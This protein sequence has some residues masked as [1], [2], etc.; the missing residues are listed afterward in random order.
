MYRFLII[1]LACVTFILPQCEADCIWYGVCNPEEIEDGEMPLNCAVNAPGRPITDE[2]AQK[3]MLRLCPD[4]FT[5][6]K[7]AIELI[8]MVYDRE[9]FS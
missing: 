8:P 6:C 1:T 2:K 4:L 5:N 3:T 7:R 9:R